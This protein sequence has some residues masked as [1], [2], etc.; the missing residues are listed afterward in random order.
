MSILDV[1]EYSES[2]TATL[3]EGVVLEQDLALKVNRIK[4]LKRCQGIFKS[5]GFE[6]MT[7]SE[8]LSLE[9]D[10]TVFKML[11]EKYFVD[12]ENEEEEEKV[13]V[14]EGEE[15]RLSDPFEMLSVLIYLQETVYYSTGTMDLLILFGLFLIEWKEFDVIR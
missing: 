5:F 15:L 7:Y 1:D 14:M 4:Q 3:I 12:R 11:L 9:Q 6:K 13:V 8:L 10:H 2:N